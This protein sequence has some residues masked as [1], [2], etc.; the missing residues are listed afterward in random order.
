MK[1]IEVKSESVET[2]WGAV[3]DAIV[4]SG[5]VCENCYERDAV[6]TA[7]DETPLCQPCADELEAL[8]INA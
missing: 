4:E 8:A 2:N 5:T 1:Q 7:Y 6:T 3:V